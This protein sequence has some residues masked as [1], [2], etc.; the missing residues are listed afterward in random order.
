MGM[1]EP[2][3]VKS[4][5]LEAI[6]AS[7]LFQALPD[8]AAA[9]D[10]QL[11]DLAFQLNGRGNYSSFWIEAIR[12]AGMLNEWRAWQKPAQEEIWGVSQ[13][14]SWGWKGWQEAAVEQG[15]GWREAGGEA[16]GLGG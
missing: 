1:W 16:E 5:L 12:G 13:E 15:T 8:L 9:A 7:C 4:A 3:G 14:K 2:E 11:Y 10:G 6:N